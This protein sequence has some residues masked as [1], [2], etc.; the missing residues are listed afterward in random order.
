LPSEGDVDQLGGALIVIVGMIIYLGICGAFGAYTSAEKGR[1]W[2][3]GLLFGLLLGPFGVIAAACLPDLRKP[4]PPERTQ[5]DWESI[6][7][8][9]RQRSEQKPQTSALENEIHRAIVQPDPTAERRAKEAADQRL[10]ENLGSMLAPEGQTSKPSRRQ[11][12]DGK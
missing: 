6:E 12:A 7:R 2:T 9:L 10:R 4:A 11:K 3:E 1:A 8:R 5:Q